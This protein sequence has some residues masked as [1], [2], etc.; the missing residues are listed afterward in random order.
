MIDKSLFSLPGI[1]SIL[2]LLVLFAVFEGAAVFGQAW[3]LSSAITNLWYGSALQ[4]QLLWVALFLLSFIGMQGMRYVQDLVLD[5]YAFARADDLRHNLTSTLFSSGS[6]LVQQHGTGNTTTLLLEG[7]EQVETYLRLVLQKMVHLVIIPVLLLVPVFVLDWI[8]GIILLVV[9]P[10]IILYMVLLGRL[11]QER[12]VKQH[13]VFKLLSNHFID[14]LRGIDTLKLF[15]ASSKQGRGIYQVSE[16]FR[17]ATVKTLSVA[18]LSSAVLDLLATFSVAAVAIMLGLRLL[19]GSLVLFPALT[20]LLLAPEYFKPIREFASDFHASL[21]GRNALKSLLEILAGDKGRVAGAAADTSEGGRKTSGSVILSEEKD[22]LQASN[23][24]L[25]VK[26]PSPTAQD[27]RKSD[28]SHSL[29]SPLSASSLVAASSPLPASS[30]ST[31]S[32]PLSAPP[33][34]APLSSWSSDATISVDK[35]SFSYDEFEA[36]CDISFAAKGFMKVGVIGTSGAGKSTLIHLLGGFYEAGR[37][38][39]CINGAEL[40]SLRQPRWQQLVAYLP[41]DPYIFHAT[42]RENITFYHPGATNA[43]VSEAVATVGLEDLVDELPQ[44]LATKIGEG[45]RALSGGQA[46]RVAL[47]RVCLDPKRSVLLFDEPT[48]HL[49][50]ETELELKQRML[51]LM[52][53][54]LVFFATHRLH[55]MQEM[56]LI[57]VMEQGRIVA[58]GSFEELQMQSGEFASLVSRLRGGVA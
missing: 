55:W 4:D 51:P 35:L 38:T 43:E 24:T 42:L 56:D 14:T 32:P 41:Q 45:A 7:V 58:Q 22:T 31:A 53:D 27:D 23:E 29:P 5:R 50:I 13:K 17:K 1:R 40:T 8:S 37:G 57:L 34:L 6:E 25:R 44:G 15:G 12:A 9:F 3:S 21:D 26:D 28:I 30:L 19:E 36:L 33:S 48:A 52:Q 47:A 49:D 46:Q 11:A 39:L 10:F 2:A 18:T 20:V 54:K 16:K